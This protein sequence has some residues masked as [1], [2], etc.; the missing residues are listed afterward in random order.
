[1]DIAISKITPEDERSTNARYGI[2][3]YTIPL[4]PDSLM[5]SVGG[6]NVENFL[7]VG[8]AWAQVVSRYTTP[9]C[10]LLDIGSGCGRTARMLVNNRHITSYIGFDVIAPNVIWCNTYVK[11]AFGERKCEFYHFDIHSREYNPNGALQAKDFEFPCEDASVDVILAASV[12]THLLEPDANH[13]LSE[14]ARVLRKAGTAIVSIHT[15]VGPS[16]KFQGGEA[17]IDVDQQYFTDMARAAGLECKDFIPDLAGQT[18]LILH[19]LVKKKHGNIVL[20][21]TDYLYRNSTCSRLLMLIPA[22]FRGKVRE[23]LTT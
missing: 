14:I 19:R 7:V 5:W 6:Q 22:G 8:D 23:W 17:R 9:E 18:A 1:M 13:Y 12:F 10:T 2:W 11:P 4:P 20:R 3:K 16:V 15:N 21:I